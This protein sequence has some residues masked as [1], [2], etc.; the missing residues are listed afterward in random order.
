MTYVKYEISLVLDDGTDI[1]ALDYIPS[2]VEH[3]RLVRA[4]HRLYWS[5]YGVTADK[6]T[7]CIADFDVYSRAAL[8]YCA[9]TRKSAPIMPQTRLLLEA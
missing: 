3:T 5:L 9:I 6:G 2:L 4:G 1:T 7:F 8:R